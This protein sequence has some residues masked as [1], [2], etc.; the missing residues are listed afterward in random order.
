MCLGLIGNSQTYA[1]IKF[2]EEF[3][4]YIVKHDKNS[5][6][7]LNESANY[8]VIKG[9]DYFIEVDNEY[10]E[11]DTT[12]LLA[13]NTDGKLISRTEEFCSGKSSGKYYQIVD[14]TSNKFALK[15]RDQTPTLEGYDDNGGDS[16]YTISS[17]GTPTINKPDK[18]SGYENRSSTPTVYEFVNKEKKAI[19]SDTVEGIYI[20]IEFKKENEED[21]ELKA[22]TVEPLKS[23]GYYENNVSDAKI[24]NKYKLIHCK[25]DNGGCFL[26]EADHTKAIYY[27]DNEAGGLITVNGSN[28]LGKTE[29]ANVKNGLY[30]NIKEKTAVSCV[31]GEGCTNGTKNYLTETCNENNFGNVRIDDEENI[32]V[33]ANYDT[34]KS[35]PVELDIVGSGTFIVNVASG[36]FPSAT[37]AGKIQLK[38]DNDVIERVDDKT[39]CSA[40]S[41][42]IKI[43]SE[44]YLCTGVTDSGEKETVTDPVSGETTQETIYNSIKIPFENDGAVFVMN[45]ANG[46]K[47]FTIDENK[48]DLKVTEGYYIDRS[49]GKEEGISTVIVGC[50]TTCVALTVKDN[51]FYLNNEKKYNGES[52]SL[53][54]CVSDGNT[55]NE[56]IECSLTNG[57]GYYTNDSEGHLIKCADNCEIIDTF[58]N[59]EN[60]L[61]ANSS[62]DLEKPI[63]ECN[64]GIGGKKCSAI[65]LGT[66]EEVGT[67]NYIN[68]DKSMTLIS[69]EKQEN[70]T[71]EGSEE[72]VYSNSCSIYEAPKYTYYSEKK[73]GRLIH[74]DVDNC[75]FESLRGNNYYLDSMKTGYIIECARNVCS[76]VLGN[77]YYLDSSIGGLNLIQCYDSA[78]TPCTKEVGIS[79]GVYVTNGNGN[80]LIILD[81]P[82]SNGK[83][84]PARSDTKGKYYLNGGSDKGTNPLIYV[85][86]IEGEP[87]QYKWKTG[88]ADANTAYVNEN[89]NGIIF[90]TATNSCKEITPIANSKYLNINS[91]KLITCS[92]ST[93]CVA[94]DITFETGEKT[95]AYLINQATGELLS[96]NTVS[97]KL[98]ECTK[99][100]D[101]NNTIECALKTTGYLQYYINAGDSGKTLIQSNSNVLSVLTKVEMGYYINS[102]DKIIKCT[103]GDS[104]KCST[105]SQGGE[106][107]ECNSST[108][109]SINNQLLCAG[110]DGEKSITY[111]TTKNGKYLINSKAFVGTTA[112]ILVE[113]I[114]NKMVIRNKPTV[115]EYYLLNESTSTL[116]TDGS[117]GTLY[118]CNSSSCSKQ[119][120]NAEQSYPN[121]D[122]STVKNYPTIKCTNE[123]S[124]Y[125]CKFVAKDANSVYCLNNSKALFT[126]NKTNK[127]EDVNETENTCTKQVPK[128][129]YYLPYKND[130]LYKCTAGST[131]TEVTT[132][133]SQVL[134]EGYYVSQDPTN[135]LIYCI[136]SLDEIRCDY[137]SNPKDGYYRG[138]GCQSG[139]LCLINCKSNVCELKSKS[140]VGANINY[141]KSG[142]KVLTKCEGASCD[143]QSK[144]KEG[145]YIN[146][147]DAFDSGSGYKLIECT[148]SNS[149]VNC[150]EKKVPNDGYLLNSGYTSSSNYFIKCENGIVNTESKVPGK[151]LVN[152][153]NKQLIKCDNEGNCAYV[154]VKGKGMYYSGSDYLIMCN[155]SKECIQNEISKLNLGNYLNTDPSTNM[156]VPLLKLK[157]ILGVISVTPESG[158]NGWFVNADINAENKEKIIQCSGRYTCSFKDIKTSVCSAQI[159]G[160]FTNYYGTVRWCNGNIPEQLPPDGE[161]YIVVSYNKNNFIPG[162]NLPENSKIGYVSLKLTSIGVEL[163][164]VEGYIYDNEKLYFCKNNLCTLA[165]INNGYYL[166][167]GNGIIYSCNKVDNK[168]EEYTD[169]DQPYKPYCR[170]SNIRVENGEFQLCK[171]QD[172]RNGNVEILNNKTKEGVYLLKSDLQDKFPGT[173]KSEKRYILANVTKYSVIME[174]SVDEIAICPE[175]INEDTK[176]CL[177]KDGNLYTNNDI[178]NKKMP[179]GNGIELKKSGENK[180][181]NYDSDTNDGY[182]IYNYD[183]VNEISVLSKL[184]LN[185]GTFKYECVSGGTCVK[186]ELAKKPIT[187]YLISKDNILIKI[188]ENVKEIVEEKIL[189]GRYIGKN[190][191]ILECDDSGYCINVG[192]DNSIK[193]AGDGVNIIVTINGVDYKSSG[194]RSKFIF[195]PKSYSK[196]RD[197]NGL[198]YDTVSELTHVSFTNSYETRNIFVDSNGF[199]ISNEDD[200]IVKGYQCINGDCKEITCKNDQYYLN[201]VQSSIDDD[202]KIKD[203]SKNAIVKCS[204]KDNFPV[205]EAISCSEELGTMIY[206]NAAAQSVND[207]FILCDSTSCKTSSAS[208][209]NGLPNCKTDESGGVNNEINC[210]R[211][212]TNTEMSVGQYCIS[213]N[214]LYVTE[215]NKCKSIGSSDVYVFD[216]TLRNIKIDNIAENHYKASVYKCDDLV[217]NG[218]TLYCYRTY[219][220]IINGVEYFVKCDSYGCIR[221]EKSVL[222]NNNNCATAG[223]GGLVIEEGKIKLCKDSSVNIDVKGEEDKYYSLNIDINGNFPETYASNKILVGVKSKV[224]Y[225]NS[226]NGYILISSN[227]NKM[228]TANSSANISSNL[229][230]YSDGTKCQLISNPK[231][232]YYK[233]TYTS[234]NTIKCDNGGCLIDTE[235]S[236][237]SP[238]G[239]KYEYKSGFP[240]YG[241]ISVIT[242]VSKNEI[243]VLEANN[244]ILLSENKLASTANVKVET[245]VSGNGLYQCN[246]SIGKCSKMTVDDGWYISGDEKFKAIK[247]AN[248]ECE[249]IEN[250][251]K[252]CTKEG[253]F[254]FKDNEY[255]FCI[256]SG[257]VTA[258]KI[259]DSIG[260]SYKLIKSDQIFPN[261]KDYVVIN[262]NSVIGIGTVSG[263]ST[264]MAIPTC[265]SVT[266]NNYCGKSTGQTDYHEK[267]QYCIKDGKIYKSVEDTENNNAHRCELQFKDKSDVHIYNGSTQ[268]NSSTDGEPSIGSQ[269]Y[270]CNGDDG[271]RVATGYYK[272]DSKY[273]RCDFSG[274]KEVVTG[275]KPGN[276]NNSKKLVV[277]TNVNGDM[278]AGNYY[279]ISGDNEFPGAENYEEFLVE[280]GEKYFIIFKGLSGYYLINSSNV[281]MN[282]DTEPTEEQARK[283]RSIEVEEEED[284][285]DDSNVVFSENVEVNEVDG[286][287]GYYSEDINV[288]KRASSNTLYLCD[289]NTGNCVVQS[290]KNGYYLNYANGSKYTNMAIIMCSDGLCNLAS[291]P[292][293]IFN[294]VQACDKAQAGVVLRTKSTANYKFCYGKA[295]NSYVDI[296]DKAATKY[297]LMTLKK[298]DMFGAIDLTGESVPE[299]VEVNVF[300]KTSDKGVEQFTKEGYVIFANNNIYENVNEKGALHYC[301]EKILYS[302]SSVKTVQ[303]NP[304]ANPGNGWYFNYN[305]FGDKR[306]IKCQDSNCVIVEAVENDVCDN[307]GSLIYNNNSFKLCLTY[308]KQITISSSDTQK[309]VMEVSLAS[310]FPG[311]KNN[312]TTILVGM[313][314]E[315]I[316]NIKLDSFVVAYDNGKLY[317]NEGDGILYSCV[318]G[319]CTPKYIAEDGWYIK[320]DEKN[321][322]VE[323]I[324]CY[325]NR[326]VVKTNVKQG[327]YK[328]ANK[329]KPII[330][331]ILPGKLIDGS[332]IPD[333]DSTSICF[334]KDY[335]EGWYLNADDNTNTFKPLINCNKETGCSESS[336]ALS[337]WYMNNAYLNNIYSYGSY[338]NATIYPLIECTSST[339][340]E[341]YEDNIGKSCTKSGEVIMPSANTFKL[342][343]TATTNIDFNKSSSTNYQILTINSSVDFPGSSSGDIIV[344][345]TKNEAVQVINDSDSYYYKDS[346]LYNCINTCTK[347]TEEGI[348]V[349]EKLTQNLMTSSNCKDSTC[350]WSANTKE[351]NMFIDD[352]NKLVVS[353]TQEPNKLYRCKKDGRYIIC[354]DMKIINDN[355][356]Y[357]IGYYY[358]NDIKN[359]KQA[360]VKTLYRY[361]GN[362]WKA[363]DND[364]SKVSYDDIG[365]CT[366]VS[367]KRTC[368]ISYDN[369]N[370]GFTTGNPVIAPG[371]LCVNENGKLFLAISEINTGIEK[372]NCVQMSDS[373]VGYYRS[374][375]NYEVYALD[376]YSAYSINKNNL[377]DSMTGLSISQGRNFVG[378][379]KDSDNYI[380]DNTI[381]CIGDSCKSEKSILC[382][383]DFQSGT[384]KLVSGT[385]KAGQICTSSEN[386]DNVYLALTNLST[387]SQGKCVK[388]SNSR[389]VLNSSYI[390]KYYSSGS[391]IIEPYNYYEVIDGKMYVINSSNVV[392]VVGE[393]IYIL[394]N[395]NIRVDINYAKGNSID[396]SGSAENGLNLYVCTAN[397]CELKRSCSNGEYNEY[398][399]DVNGSSS[400]IYKCN[401]KTNTLS[402][403]VP[404]KKTGYYINKP[405]NNL[406][407][408]YVNS[409]YV[410][411]CIVKKTN[412]GMEGY[413]VDSG[414]EGMIIK[415]VR[416]NDEY[417]CNNEKMIECE[418]DDKEQKC[419]SNVDLLRN[420]YCYY[421][422]EDKISGKIKKLVYVENFIKSGDSGKCVASDGNEYYYKYS[423]SKF[424][425][426]EKR[427]DLIRFNDNSI[428][429]IYE[430][431]VGFYIISTES[432]MGITDDTVVNK[433]RMYKCEKQDC[434][435]FSDLI[436]GNIYI[437]KA[438]KEKI[439]EYNISEGWIVKKR[440]CDVVYS[441]VSQCRLT[442]E[443]KEGDIIYLDND[444]S[445][446]IYSAVNDVN[447]VTDKGYPTT[448]NPKSSANSGHKLLWNGYYQYIVSDSRLYILN[449]NGQTFDIV[450]EKGYYMFEE[451]NH[452]NMVG[453]SSNVNVTSGAN[454][455]YVYRNNGGLVTIEGDSSIGREGYYWN[456]ADIKGLGIYIQYMDVPE[457]K[458]PEETKTKRELINGTKKFKAIR[459]RCT[460]VKKNICINTEAQT[461]NK[462]SACV[463]LEGEFKGLYYATKSITNSQNQSINCVKYD[464]E[465]VYEYI[466]ENT[467]FAGEPHSLTVLEIGYDS[468]KP[469][470]NDISDLSDVNEYDEGY[471]V[472]DNDK[473]ILKSESSQQATAYKC[474]RVSEEENGEE[475]P[476]SIRYECNT[477]LNPSKYYYAK[478]PVSNTG[479]V[480][481]ASGNKWN[482][483]GNDYYFYN[484]DYRG[485]TFVKAGDDEEVPE[486][487]EGNANVQFTGFYKNAMVT[488]RTVIV[489]YNEED[490]NAG[491]IDTEI[492]T[493]TVAKDGKCTATESLSNVEICYDS[494]SDKLYLSELMESENEEQEN[495]SMC[496]TG[497]EKDIK[498]YF[499]NNILYKMDGKS[500]QQMKEG[501]YVLNENWKEFNS[502]YPEEPMLVVKCE[503][504]NCEIPSE[505]ISDLSVIINEAAT[506]NNRLLK[507]YED[508][509]K[510]GNVKQSGFYFLNKEGEIDTDEDDYYGNVKN[511]RFVVFENGHLGSDMKKNNGRYVAYDIEEKKYVNVEFNENNVYINYA[512]K[513]HFIKGNKEYK[514]TALSY[515]SDKDRIKFENEINDNEK[516]NV[517]KFIGDEL[518]ILRPK[519]LEGIKKGMYIIKNG[520]PFSSVEWTSLTNDKEVCYY[521]GSKCDT[522]ILN[523]YKKQ[524]Y[525]INSAAES[526]SIV[527]YNEEDDE[528]KV[529][530]ENGYYFFFEDNHSINIAD[531][532]VGKVIQIVDGNIYDITNRER[533]SGYYIFNDLIVRSNN[534]KWDDAVEVRENVISDKKS[535]LSY[536]TGEVINSDSYCYNSNGVCVVKD[537][538]NESKGNENC[539]FSNDEKNYYYFVNGGLYIVNKL[540]YQRVGKSGIYITDKLGKVYSNKIENEAY[541]YVCEKEKCHVEN[542]LVSNYYLNMANINENI[543]IILYFDRNVKSW[544][545]TDKNGYYFFNSKGYPVSGDEDVEFAFIVSNNGNVIKNISS[546]NE[547]GTFVSQ[548]SPEED[549]VIIN[550]GKW[551]KASKV[552]KCKINRMNKK[553]TSEQKL[554]P[555]DVCLDV[556]T[557][558]LIKSNGIKKRQEEVT[559]EESYDAIIG[560]SEQI[561]YFYNESDMSL[562]KIENNNISPVEADGYVI[563]DKNTSIPLK[564]KEV[565]EADAYICSGNKCS[566]AEASSLIDGNYYINEESEELPLV[567]YTKGK[568]NVV[569][570]EG[571]YFFDENNIPIEKGKVAEKVFNVK[572][573]GANVEQEDLSKSNNVGIY[574]NKA[575]N[576]KVI[577]RNNGEYWV[578]A[579]ELNQCNVVENEEGIICKTLK[580]NVVY[581]AGNYCTSKDK[582]Y[583]IISD[584]IFN[585]ETVNNCMYG[586]NENPKYVLS[587]KVGKLNGISI[588]SRLIELTNESIEVAGPGYYILNGKGEVTDGNNEEN[589]EIYKCTESEC[590]IE[591]NIEAGEKFLSKDDIVYEVDEEN[592]L[593]VVEDE[594]IYFFDNSGKAC[595]EETD[596]IENIVEIVNDGEEVRVE[597]LDELPVGAYVNAADGKTVGVNDGNNWSIEIKDCEYLQGTCTNDRIVLDIGSYCVVNGKMYIIY[598]IDEEGLKKCIPGNNEKPVYFNNKSGLIVVKDTSVSSVIEEGYY[599]VSEMT[600][601]A[602][603]SEELINSK[604]IQCSYGGECAEI[605]PDVGSY[606]NRSP[607]KFNIVNFPTGNVEEAKTINNMC[608]VNEETSICSVDNGKLNVGDVCIASSALYLVGDENKC[609]KA[610]KSFTTY[611]MVNNKVYMLTDDSVI[612]KFDG[613]YFMN[614]SNRAITNKDDYSK[615]DTVAYMCSKAGDCYPL[616]PEGVKYFIDYTTMKSNKFNI[617]KYDPNNKISVSRRQEEET[618]E[619]GN[620]GYENVTEEGIYKLDDGSYAECEID[621]NEE[622]SCHTIDN[623]GSMKTVDDE[624]IVC[625]ENDEGE[626]ECVQATEGGYYVIDGELMNCEPNED[627]DQLVCEEMQ[628]EGYFLASPDDILYE[629]VEAN[630]ETTAV[631]DEETPEVDISKIYGGLDANGENSNL[632]DVIDSDPE[633]TTTSVDT[634][635]TTTTESTTTETTT[636]STTTDETTTSST[637]SATQTPIDVVCKPVECDTENPVTFQ[638]EEGAVEKYVCRKT[639][640]GEKWEAMECNNY[641][642]DGDSYECDD[643]KGGI[644]EENV[645]KPNEDHTS[646]TKSSTSTVPTTVDSSTIETTTT[647]VSTETTTSDKTNT[648]DVPESSTTTDS[649]T[650][651]TTTTTTESTTSSTTTTTTTTSSE[652]QTTS[653]TE[654]KT[655]TTKT[656]TK[657]AATST[658]GSGA[659]SV[660]RSIPKF[661]FYLILFIFSL[662]MFM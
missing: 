499:I 485:A 568:W 68:A 291:S 215:T 341:Y 284:A 314:N 299:N 454:D 114:A 157:N 75:T 175:E 164:S 35:K 3:E 64:N 398:I 553:I 517:F 165:T 521:T 99:N 89:G 258:V 139:Y 244:F 190:G 617:I 632:E 304:I 399:Y 100:D 424:L 538:I 44:Y 643:D 224:A 559:E 506:S 604:F 91:K 459:N 252:S 393:G 349:Y 155:A 650:T 328:S 379:L 432:N 86:E 230:Y 638:S 184:Y 306:Y 286:N 5:I 80:E 142:E 405:W 550:S 162:V 369:E 578:K 319:V 87:T 475:I 179:N 294:T 255:Q 471:Y 81:S 634:T 413:Y 603:E 122:S 514:S 504:Y 641:I 39:K 359:E 281:M 426:H 515:D 288:V 67:F 354:Y 540:M 98:V 10:S 342:C 213:D 335:K 233:S 554:K 130:R 226:N 195:N 458:Q 358:N 628:V 25:E 247:C 9:N 174:E 227:N 82:T 50:S 57:S 171:D 138:N 4:N 269:M 383:Y 408:C 548:S 118:M 440:R 639:D 659:L 608:N 236:I 415:C 42:I 388:Y 40:D 406:I 416:E 442:G 483:K 495:V 385:L 145:W 629:C 181:I 317:T 94:S 207:A 425:G 478:D 500:V 183:S 72:K 29:K 351:G 547:K 126:C 77:N 596:V 168:C 186:R 615:P 571:Y 238:N 320:N 150:E 206:E 530:N 606:L 107:Y 512:K 105:Y 141:F 163:S 22:A 392:K 78:T 182:F 466:K 311:L 551:N 648:S 246:S 552:P 430:E 196:K 95:N 103:G 364:I 411:E 468:I 418:Y 217:I 121:S 270:Y 567:K 581:A 649:S 585:G 65:T 470:K 92:S 45:T 239:I 599:A 135:N 43:D 407:K 412:D 131:C 653:K 298:D 125:E 134:V 101:E 54:K 449:E 580:E 242:V 508:G 535:C 353:T 352:K 119:N 237:F 293:V 593:V 507:V 365:R 27:A 73:G 614:G 337:G 140:D 282:E 455:F 322:P 221:Y 482:V 448:I 451:A 555:G 556:K 587:D 395:N 623:T 503:E 510:L 325:S 7:N 292:N 642:K 371:S 16:C 401:P 404:E 188:R 109:G 373:S 658:Q 435:E 453:Y 300:V 90:C 323:L 622:V 326:C 505:G 295:S 272:F 443:I 346:N 486:D 104:N 525:V 447:K 1:S 484:K 563:I 191:I 417:I 472:I 330:Q 357:P 331:C 210:I 38:V 588:S 391:S 60:Y 597:R 147:G 275:T 151:Y 71:K 59:V 566:I 494:V 524:K 318:S 187:G 289:N 41:D 256:T 594:G 630:E 429:S 117:V 116:V 338:S 32:V 31:K 370:Y 34:T 549:I 172:E 609:V 61:N 631:D 464:G 536:E 279:H 656:T 577:V 394:N 56:K 88:A 612:Q 600:M 646:T 384:C 340:C 343:K 12:K 97:G 607:N 534:E 518:Y 469:F 149:G 212:D 229:L 260:N 450:N 301:K 309:M 661:T 644:P 58:N 302:G 332:F 52:G 225:M 315:S 33:C 49:G 380:V 15:S 636:T 611:Q 333:E 492:K 375:N 344:K 197:G 356:S 637:P 170:K 616:D 93:N 219:G 308:D 123:S 280:A 444:E 582:L 11:A 613:Y 640:D 339:S 234:K 633:D 51:D 24:K 441:N 625:T 562:V 516:K 660:M 241:D 474:G 598:D 645:E 200:E 69:C 84:D 23:E 176:Y 651:T 124:G 266:N 271:C 232:G 601:E 264:F 178:T 635:S 211:A 488:D 477:V 583:I 463:I 55:T 362:T 479:Y 189:P 473:K 169:N 376:G 327:F 133:T 268:L 526:L 360:T 83:S 347:V 193:T 265:R 574:F 329:S 419:S 254:I 276:L 584:A 198:S 132:K 662:Y 36:K 199:M 396:I 231:Y 19:Q 533:N 602:L 544:K 218:N 389:K 316:Y 208:S 70:G 480:M 570:N 386:S 561:Q 476:D 202:N 439:V 654:T 136:K 220:Y 626:V 436:N 487:I 251:N 248:K 203:R 546:S 285:V 26:Y 261:K 501:Y 586:T 569:G 589:M 428:V 253:D 345:V 6:F 108:V 321:Q 402:I 620:S 79:R 263:G 297:Y 167:Y 490:G 129:G 502:V 655:S 153:K 414:N 498:Y 28:E 216:N 420:S 250:L 166:D 30:V 222:S 334:E 324:Y 545:K 541:V 511:N 209:V 452:Y 185:K 85:E 257:T 228:I 409:Q 579:E 390:E 537:I 152:A 523:L 37:A 560:D 519:M 177:N 497:D 366:Y 277:K 491:K 605:E 496:Y 543:P 2:G 400:K 296:K 245:N 214:K 403:E 422:M 493:C 204:L 47:V 590:S 456:K 20:K 74:C 618:G 460:S 113:V 372:E 427:N 558:V 539:V 158:I 66:P 367:Y 115:N 647:E 381:S 13:A 313:D 481:Y 154:E 421:D 110:Y 144:P 522:N 621:D 46:Y 161:R 513:D 205:F 592:K 194:L 106:N 192:T 287:V 259:K 572:V 201:T 18:C 361:D 156:N 382:S 180:A 557:L 53:I 336:A 112:N 445:I 127:C 96:D 278:T 235:K 624:I 423:D 591:S 290:V 374:E 120:V 160:E 267:D 223:V 137:V 273:Y 310:E 249:L 14:S 509:S 76:S 489:S 438:S 437:N 434:V 573:N 240:G 528:W 102:S 576:N 305:V 48:Y 657:P 387:S 303:C 148:S 532:R 465:T 575:N 262:T 63:I 564:S 627:E 173:E 457:K 397:G 111:S 274:C 243:N 307:S 8:Y 348:T 652:T 17:D 368:Y 355:V 529:V 461:I 312:K 159:N 143:V 462:G 146:G 467:E 431:N 433:S 128:E 363:L 283:K 531:R 595:T 377:V 565:V 410:T 446:D 527:E 62:I 610:E 350:N 21:T 619:E 520:V 542:N 378:T